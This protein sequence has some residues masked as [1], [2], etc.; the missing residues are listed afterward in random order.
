M[1]EGII[2][3]TGLMK[4]G[5]HSLQKMIYNSE[6]EH[7]SGEFIKMLIRYKN[8]DIS[9]RVFLGYLYRYFEETDCMC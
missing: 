4:S 9:K 3:C 6:H 8:Y 5:T 1:K 2:I 7:E